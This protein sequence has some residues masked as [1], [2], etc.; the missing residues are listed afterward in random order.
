MNEIISKVNRKKFYMEI[1]TTGVEERLQL[2]YREFFYY[3]K[4]IQF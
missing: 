3:K 1:E 2:N 4:N